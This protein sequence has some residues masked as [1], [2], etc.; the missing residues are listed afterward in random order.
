[1]R[2]RLLPACCL[3]TLSMSFALVTTPVGLGR[4]IA[5]G[6]TTLDARGRQIPCPFFRKRAGDAVEALVSV[7]SFIA[8]RHK[9][10]D[11]GFD[12]LLPP[13]PVGTKTCHLPVEVVMA[14]IE[15]DIAERQYY[16]SGR[17]SQELY[18]DGC[19]FD[20]PDPDMPVRSLA[21]YM[22]ALRG[23]FD[24]QRS[25][26]E[27]VRMEARGPTAFVAHWRLSGHLKL[28]WRPAIKPY[29]GCTLYETSPESGLIVSHTEA[30]SLTA[31]DAFVSTCL[32]SYGAP[33]APEVSQHVDVAPPPFREARAPESAALA[34][35]SSSSSEAQ[36]SS[37][38]CR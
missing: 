5:N 28:P 3:W 18:D 1:M 27:L 13:R 12:E 10:L 19:F 21:R 37:I 8:A 6:I 24:P 17:L 11:L 35:T 25:T 7:C 4:A 33:P 38:A 32:P 22:D 15:R 29:A 16:V 2:C 23:L 31:M 36:H 30:W 26:I 14:R 20:G 34:E 9:S